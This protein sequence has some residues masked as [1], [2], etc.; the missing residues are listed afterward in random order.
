MKSALAILAHALGAL[1]FVLVAI[2]AA[3]T[4]GV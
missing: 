2:G 1:V 4:V 3:A